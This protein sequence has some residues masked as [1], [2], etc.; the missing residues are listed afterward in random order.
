MSSRTPHPIMQSPWARLVL[1]ALGALML[2]QLVAFYRL[3]VGQVERAQVREAMFLQQRNALTDCLDY[4]AGSTISSCTQRATLAVEGGMDAQPQ[5]GAAPVQ[6]AVFR[7][8][9]PVGYTAR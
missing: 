6:Q 9:V 3:C 5:R 1:A 7:S 8:A 2:I 4:R